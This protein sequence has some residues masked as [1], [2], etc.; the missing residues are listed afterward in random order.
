MNSLNVQNYYILSCVYENNVVQSVTKFGRQFYLCIS[1]SNSSF[2]NFNFS[3]TI[4]MRGICYLK[5]GENYFRVL[6]M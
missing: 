2:N 5:K 4:V 6:E 3:T 1:M